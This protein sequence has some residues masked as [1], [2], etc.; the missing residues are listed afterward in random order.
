MRKIIGQ[1][2]KLTNLNER[3]EFQKVSLLV[4]KKPQQFS[5]Q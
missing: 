1:K 4:G 2:K 5:I 3:W